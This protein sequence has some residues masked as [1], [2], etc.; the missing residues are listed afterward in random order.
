MGLDIRH[1][2]IEWFI[3]QVSNYTVVN[4]IYISVIY[5]GHRDVS[6]K[7]RRNCKQQLIVQRMFVIMESISSYFT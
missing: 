4:A 6:N 7:N 1:I 5:R 2:Q 3:L